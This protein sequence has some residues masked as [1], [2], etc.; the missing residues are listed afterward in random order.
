MT[1]IESQ[2]SAPPAGWILSPLFTQGFL[3]HT[4]LLYPESLNCSY[5]LQTYFT[6]SHTVKEPLTSKALISRNGN[7]IYKSMRKKVLNK[8]KN[9]KNVWS[10]TSQRQ[11]PICLPSHAFVGW[12]SMKGN[13]K[14]V[15]QLIN[16]K[17]LKS[18]M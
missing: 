12:P 7:S 15:S 1:T 18:I 11:R 4:F 10:D 13:L 2:L 16:W 9:C 14:A 5:H 17:F 3:S 6:I 8:E